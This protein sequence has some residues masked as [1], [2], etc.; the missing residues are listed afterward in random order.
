MKAKGKTI[1]PEFPM[2]INKYMAMK[3]ISTRRG[4]DELIAKGFVFINKKKAVL[5]DTVGENDEVTLKQGLSKKTYRYVAF[6]KPK[7]I[8]TH[9]P[10]GTEQ[11]IASLT[12]RIKNLHGLFR[13]ADS[14]KPRMDSFSLLMTVE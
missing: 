6:Y 11:D 8:I 7:G 1:T 9:S 14:T 3:G 10:Q 5:G 4:S 13:L 2:R 12:S